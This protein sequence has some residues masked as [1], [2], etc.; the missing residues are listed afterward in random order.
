MPSWGWFLVASAVIYVVLWLCAQRARGRLGLS[1]L[2]SAAKNAKFASFLLGNPAEYP[3]LRYPDFTVDMRDTGARDAFMAEL[4]ELLGNGIL[5]M[6]PGR[7]ERINKFLALEEAV[8]RPPVDQSQRF[9]VCAFRVYKSL[10]LMD[11]LCAVGAKHPRDARLAAILMQLQVSQHMA[12][13]GLLAEAELATP[14]ERGRS[15]W[16]AIGGTWEPGEQSATYLLIQLPNVKRWMER[17]MGL[18]DE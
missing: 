5:E 15:T 16:E 4:R 17:R 2:R 13:A 9:K 1:D 7:P 10:V 8:F 12:L 18:D 6:E 14:R 3:L 11:M